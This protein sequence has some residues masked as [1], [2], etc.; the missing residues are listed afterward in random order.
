LIEAKGEHVMVEQLADQLDVTFKHEDGVELKLDILYPLTGTP[1][2]P[3]VIYIFGGGWA[4]GSRSGRSGVRV[5]DDN[6]RGNG[7]AIV[8]VD[9]R[10]SGVAPYPAQIEDCQ[11]AVQW[12]RANGGQYQLKTDRLGAWGFSSGAQLAAILGLMDR[13]TS[14]DSVAHGSYSSKVQAVC[15]FAVTSDFLN[16]ETVTDDSHPVA[17]LFGGMPHQQSSLAQAASP[18]NYVNSDAA[19]FY[20][21]HG[22][23]DGVVPVTQS[24]RLHEAL[25]EHGVESTFYPIPQG[26]HGMKGLSEETTQNILYE[27]LAFFKRHTAS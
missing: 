2:Y 22:E 17:L 11:A 12:L 7:F 5:I 19:P 10:L 20:L 15:A 23:D 16:L 18:L 13:E 21:I 4:W 1:P 8:P 3:T 26:D 27:T 14:P 24:S 25:L 6:L 9:Y